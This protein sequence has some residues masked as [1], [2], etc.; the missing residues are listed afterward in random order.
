MN[1]DK[2]SD[3]SDF[4]DLMFSNSLV[5]NISKPTR[6]T[7]SSASLIDNIFTND[8]FDTDKILNGIL[9]TDISDHFPVFHIDYSTSIFKDPQL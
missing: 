9:Y 8:L 6:V 2:H 5:P 4:I 1:I 3:S 7:R